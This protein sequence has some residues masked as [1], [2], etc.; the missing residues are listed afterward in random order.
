[1]KQTIFVCLFAMLC[2]AGT[3]WGQSDSGHDCEVVQSAPDWF[4]HPPKD[5]YAG[6]SLPW[7]QYE[8]AQQQAVYVAL[9]SFEVQNPRQQFVV[10]KDGNARDD[11]SQDRKSVV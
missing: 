4:F 8:L 5:M 7:E 9:L 11:G 3:A 10:S 1:M 2:G 6:V